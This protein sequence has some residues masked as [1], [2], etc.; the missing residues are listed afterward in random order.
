M[1]V[2]EPE[3]TNVE[4]TN[5]THVKAEWEWKD[6]SG[7]TVP[8]EGYYV[9]IERKED[10]DNWVEVDRNRVYGNTYEVT[11]DPQHTQQEH[12]VYVRADTDGLKGSSAKQDFATSGKVGI[13]WE[14]EYAMCYLPGDHKSST[15]SVDYDWADYN[16]GKHVVQYTWMLSKEKYVDTAFYDFVTTETDEVRFPEDFESPDQPWDPREAQWV[17]AVSYTHL[18]LP[19]ICSV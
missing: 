19:T 10:S 7:R 14:N 15:I 9:N 3:I 5:D 16:D 4:V 2:P 6:A 8:T 11:L 18:T 17:W 1:T 13:S 12:R